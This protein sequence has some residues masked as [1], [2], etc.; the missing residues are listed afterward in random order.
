MPFT[1]PGRDTRGT[2][3]IG[4]HVAP[5][6]R[7]SKHACK[8]RYY[9]KPTHIIAPRLDQ[10]IVLHETNVRIGVGPKRI[11]APLHRLTKENLGLGR[12]PNGEELF[13]RPTQFNA[14]QTAAVTSSMNS[15]LSRFSSQLLRPRETPKKWHQAHS[16]KGVRRIL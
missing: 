9:C 12:P 8:S 11:A 14:S 15:M 2:H 4:K 3:P 13:R 5:Y 1:I 7:C 6:T 10:G 16:H